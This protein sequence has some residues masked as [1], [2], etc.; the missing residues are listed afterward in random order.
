M[1]SPSAPTSRS[2]GPAPRAGSTS[3]PSR[4]ST[5][6]RSAL[7][8]I[9]P[10]LA[11]KLPAN[12]LD[13]SASISQ[14]R[15][16]DLLFRM[17]SW[18][19]LWIPTGILGIALLVQALRR[20]ADP[21]RAVRT[22]G[23]TMAI[24]GALLAGLGAATP[25]IGDVVAPSDPGRAGAVAAFVAVLTGR[26]TGAGYALILIGL[27]LGPCAGQGRRGPRGSV[28]SVEGVGRRQAHPSGLALRRRDRPRPDR[29][30]RARARPTSTARTVVVAAAVLALYV[31][32]VVCLRA[33][34]VV[35]PRADARGLR[36]GW[37]VAVAAAMAIALVGS[38]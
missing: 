9:N 19:W 11:K 35:T 5:S 4:S 1:S 3:T 32:V 6:I 7:Q 26:L 17:S 36:R 27:A 8:S 22:I 34:N 23:V 30:V 21:V 15:I 31:G 25:V 2:S 24:S 16:V 18:I 29:V 14:N 10:A 12:V 33:A 37:I 38:A 13:A 28:A 20:A